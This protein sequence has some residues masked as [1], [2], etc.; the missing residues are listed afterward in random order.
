LVNCIR[1]NKPIEQASE[2][3]ISN[4]AALMGRES[5]YTGQETTWDAITASPLDYTPA[6][7]NIGKMDMSGFK[8]PVPG[9]AQK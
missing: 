6:D 2:T 4:L 5:A 8:T 9:T 7:L 3:A 1:S